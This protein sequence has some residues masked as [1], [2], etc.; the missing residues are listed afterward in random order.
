MISPIDISMISL[1]DR[2]RLNKLTYKNVE[3]RTAAMRNF[4]T[5]R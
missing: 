3:S 2:E 4:H 5:E 1:P